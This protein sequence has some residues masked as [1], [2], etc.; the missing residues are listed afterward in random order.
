MTVFRLCFF[1]CFSTKLYFLIK[2]DLKGPIKRKIAR[3]S[4]KNPGI[5]NNIP[6]RKVI[7]PDIISLSG[8][9]PVSYTHL[10]AH[11]TR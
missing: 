2:I 11:E 7:I 10:R 5:K 9:I 3:K 1:E 6:E 8:R 4:V